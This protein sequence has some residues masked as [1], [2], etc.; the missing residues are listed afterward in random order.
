MG[1]AVVRKSPAGERETA[2]TAAEKREIEALNTQYDE[3]LASGYGMTGEV[4]G[5]GLPTSSTSAIGRTMLAMQKFRVDWFSMPRKALF[6]VAAVLAE[7]HWFVRPVVNLNVDLYGRGFRF[8]SAVRAEVEADKVLKAYPFARVAKDL[9][10]E[11]M[12]TNNAVALWLRND[13]HEDGLPVI[14]TPDMRDCE[15][16]PGGQVLK[17]TF[18]RNAKLETEKKDI[19]G[20]DV[21]KAMKNGGTV[22]IPRDHE[23]WAWVAYTE[24]KA[25][26]GLNAP[27]VT[28][29]LDDLDF[30]EAVKV[31]DWNGAWQRRKLIL[32][33]AK[34][35]A[36]T[37]GSNAGISRGGA[38][39]GQLEIVAKWLRTL[40]GAATLSTNFD[41]EFKH[42]IFPTADHFS[43]GLT[44][45]TW[46]RLLLWA[47]FAGV[48]LFKSESQIAGVSPYLMLQ[49]RAKV[50][51][52]REDWTAFLGSIFNHES[53]RPAAGSIDLTPVF[54][55]SHLYSVVELD[56]LITLHA[57]N[58]L[59]APQDMREKLLDMDNAEQVALM[60][61]G[62]ADRMG[63]ISVFEPRQ[64]LTPGAEAPAGGEGAPSAG[65]G[66]PSESA[67]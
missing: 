29:I 35:Y 11:A 59:M 51:A 2:L 40:A 1:K 55:N 34:G 41:Q 4:Q 3:M 36:I 20:D 19:F 43:D 37:S 30:I 63:Y 39:R 13:G 7:R 25:S 56:K 16:P 24:G 57:T 58:A 44:K 17:I 14:N 42:I 31:G 26:S 65:P 6:D 18:R 21:W 49:L 47:G 50:F 38:K 12:T 46:E 61:A 9:L 66:R 64:G 48:I 33:A 67:V 5:A 45:M 28:G 27:A 10:R 22:E 54:G 53:F 62:H 52:F 60:K 8:Q 23:R 15:I 32:Q